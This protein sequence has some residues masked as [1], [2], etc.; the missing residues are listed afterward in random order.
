MR[1]GLA[2]VG[3]FV[4]AVADRNAVARPRFARADPDVLRVLRIERDRADRL[5]RL[6]V[7]DRPV[8]RSA[9][10]RFPN[11]AAGRAD[12]ERDFART[13][14]A[15]AAMAETRPLMVAEPM[16]RAPRPEMVAE[17]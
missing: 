2:A 16:L 10:F 7:E 17:L 9:V 1:P 11:A 6:L 12:E 15:F 13:A 3:R 5:H 4:D 14:L 8:M